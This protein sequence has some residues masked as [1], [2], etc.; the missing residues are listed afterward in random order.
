MSLPTQ[1]RRCGI[2]LG[3]ETTC[4]RCPPEP[5]R[6]RHMTPEEV[7]AANWER[8]KLRAQLRAM[9]WANRRRGTME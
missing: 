9:K 5:V 3:R 6:A 2:W 1:C 4:P 8:E 7:A